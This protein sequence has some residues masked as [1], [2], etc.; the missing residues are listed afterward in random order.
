MSL[1][2]TSKMLQGLGLRLPMF[3][4]LASSTMSKLGLFWPPCDLLLLLP[5]TAKR[6]SVA[7]VSK[8]HRTT[9]GISRDGQACKNSN[10]NQPLCER[11]IHCIRLSHSRLGLLTWSM[12]SSSLLTYFMSTA[13]SE[14]T[15]MANRRTS[16]VGKTLRTFWWSHCGMGGVMGGQ[17]WLGADDADIGPPAKETS[18]SSASWTAMKKM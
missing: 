7:E 15:S 11:G 14:V 8:Q 5:S 16:R 10:Q 17:D 18:T 12:M 13:S 4:A 1:A 9:T 6:G 2:S 3:R